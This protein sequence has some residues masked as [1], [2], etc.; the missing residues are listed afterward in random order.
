MIARILSYSVALLLSIVLATYTTTTTADS[1]EQIVSAENTKSAAASATLH[2]LTVALSNDTYP[3]MFVNPQGQPEGLIIDFWREIAAQQQFDIEFIMAEW[4]ET[5]ALLDAGKVD[6]HGGMA[7][8]EQ[9]AKDYI[10]NSINITIYSNVFVHRDVLRVQTLA[11]LSPYVIGVVEN[12]SH[13][14]TLARLLPNTPLR[15]FATFSHMYDAALAGELKA[16]AVLDRLPPRYPAYKELDNQFPLYQKVPLEAINLVYALPLHSKLS[17]IIKQYVAAMPAQRINELER[18]WLGFQVDDDA[19]L[20]LGLSVLNQPY[21]HV[22]AQGEAAGLLVDIWRLW[23]EKTGTR[24]A[25]VPHNSANSLT[26]LANKRIDAH[27]GFPAGADLNPQLAKAYHIYS[28]ATAYFTLRSQ[29]PLALDR[30]TSA[31]IGIFSTATYLTE[32]Q[33]LYPKVNFIRFTS[34]E[35]LTKATIDGDING[36]FGAE[37]VM[38]ARLKQLNLWENFV[39]FPTQRLFSPLYVIVNSDNKA[40]AA[41]ITEGF[42]QISLAELIQIEQKWITSPEHSYFTDY[43]NKIPLTADERAWLIEHSPLR[44]GL[45]NNWPPM[46]FV[47][48]EGNISGVS[49]E[50]LQILASRL[51][52]QLELQTFDNFDEMLTALENRQL[53][54][55]ANVSPRAGRDAFARFTEPFW[56]VRWAVISHINSDNISQTS[57]LRTKRVAIFRDYQLAQHLVDMVPDV[58]VIEISQ[59]KDGI[60]LLQENKVDF[61]L[62]S[63]EAGSRALK[64]T[65]AI[66][67]RMQIIDDVPDYPSLLAVRSDYAPLVTILNKGL[68]SIGM[69]ERE[70][71]YQH[72]FDFEIT[73]GVDLKRLNQ[74]IWQVVTVSLLFLAVFVTWNLF[75]RREVGLRRN[76]EQ[77]MRFMATHDDLTGLPNRS[78]VKERLEQALAQHS[79]HNEILAVLFLDLDGFK[80]VNDSHGHAA[81]DELLLKLSV[82]LQDCVRKSDTVA[83]FGGDEFVLLLTGLLNRDDAAIVAEKI[84]FQLQQQMHL[85]FADVNVSASIGIAIYPYDG[86]DSSML[87]KQADKQMYQAK[88]QGK[89]GYSFT[90]QEFS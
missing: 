37:V 11:D 41:T 51:E 46:E 19:T 21:M 36:F 13:V 20:L 71:I 38:E 2:K 45:V 57:Q 4:P 49:H 69:P 58:Q 14:S 78:L 34:H 67:L 82:V 63:I 7:Y 85:S 64:Q 33:Q 77:K 27:I 29:T 65:N 54:F 70:Q 18:K 86:T 10:L 42:N 90:E 74:I 89:N 25:F 52:L 84:L 73:Q 47:D 56:S 88:Q 80:E 3:Y 5:V 62:D 59:L 43:K 55:I 87:L 76:A 68:R 6:M 22:T 39:A 40:L 9:R 35:D 66:N 23:S 44:V 32:L 83:R 26:N 50:M 8:T 60:R 31:N 79:R 15:P 24:I 72:W 48:E 61:V 12:S 1:A 81:G 16:F 17:N 28:F 53:D 30:N 75:L